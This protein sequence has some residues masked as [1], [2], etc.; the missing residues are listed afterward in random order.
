MEVVK[1]VVKKYLRL[2]KLTES[3]IKALIDAGIDVT[4]GVR[5]ANRE[6]K[7][8]NLPD[9]VYVVK[10]G[11]AITLPLTIKWVNIQ[12]ELNRLS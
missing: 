2:D 4:P 9:G 10:G 1:M 12:K 11:K 3:Q 6:V 5:K 7:T 8:V